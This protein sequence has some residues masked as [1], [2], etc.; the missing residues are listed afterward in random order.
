MNLQKIEQKVLKTNSE[1]LGYLDDFKVSDNFEDLSES[2]GR[3]LKLKFIKNPK[4]LLI[5]PH[6]GYRIPKPVLLYLNLQT[7]EEL[8]D[9]LSRVETR[10][11]GLSAFIG[12]LLKH[13]EDNNL[14]WAVGF[15]N[16]HRSLV[17]SNRAL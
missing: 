3:I 7:E 2:F 15:F 5:F 12:I 14:D 4:T 11:I 13:I 17:D 10:D 9:A 16:I 1:Y 6:S 8:T